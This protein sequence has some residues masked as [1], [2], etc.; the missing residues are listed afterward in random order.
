M[1]SLI[2]DQ[3]QR[4]GPID[5]MFLVGGF[6][7]SEYLYHVL[8]SH[9]EPRVVPSIVMAPRGDVAIARGAV[10][11]ACGGDPKVSSRIVRRTYGLRTRM[12][13]Q[14]GLDSESSAVVTD[15]GVKRCSTRFDV[16]VSKGERVDVDTRS[17]RRFWVRYPKNTEG[18]IPSQAI[19]VKPTVVS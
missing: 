9:F 11:V 15:D 1:I 19:N 12:V 13:F 4:G 17:S 8:K 6:G 18:M 16:M 10:Y 3:L 2:E 7:C 5:A 14:E